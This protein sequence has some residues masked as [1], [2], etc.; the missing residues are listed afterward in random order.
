MLFSQEYHN[1]F[2]QLTME[3]GIILMTSASLW[4][5]VKFIVNLFRYN[6]ISLNSLQR[7]FKTLA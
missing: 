2:A 1:E 7:D 4:K 5:R 3:G 6:N